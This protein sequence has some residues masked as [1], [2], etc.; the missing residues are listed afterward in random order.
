[1]LNLLLR[2]MSEG[3]CLKIPLVRE[4]HHQFTVD[5]IARSQRAISIT[6][7]QSLATRLTVGFL[8]SLG[9]SGSTAGSFNFLER[10]LNEAV[11]RRTLRVR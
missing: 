3:D 10:D 9:P 8:G 5:K 4:M 7:N 6:Q 11:R 2:G 1:M